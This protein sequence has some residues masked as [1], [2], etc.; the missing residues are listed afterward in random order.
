[1]ANEKWPSPGNQLVLKYLL[2]YYN[3]VFVMTF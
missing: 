2:K 1:M 3:M